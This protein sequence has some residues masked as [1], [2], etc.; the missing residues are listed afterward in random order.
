MTSE[1]NSRSIRLLRITRLLVP[2][3]AVSVIVMSVHLRA[4]QASLFGTVKHL[5]GAFQTMASMSRLCAGQLPGRD[6]DLYLG[7][8]PTASLFPAALLRGCRFGDSQYSAHLM[9]SLAF[10]GGLF[11]LVW[12]SHWAWAP[13]RSRSG[14]AWCGLAVVAVVLFLD[15]SMSPSQS[16]ILRIVRSNLTAPG[17]SLLMLR[18]VV[19]F[20]AAIATIVSRRLPDNARALVLGGL[21]GV[22]ILWS[23]DTGVPTAAGIGI[24]FLAGPR[25]GRIDAGAVARFSVGFLFAL[26]TAV[27]VT[28]GGRPS[29]QVAFRAGVADAQFWYFSASGDASRYFD[30]VDLLGWFRRDDPI[31]SLILLTYPFLLLRLAQ[32]HRR[33]SAAAGAAF[34]VGVGTFFGAALS[35]FGGHIFVRYYSAAML[36]WPF[37]LVIAL[38][39]SSR[40]RTTE[41]PVSMESRMSRGRLLRFT[42]QSREIAAHVGGARPA[43]AGAVSLVAITTYVMITQQQDPRDSANRTYVPNLAATIA[44]PDMADIELARSLTDAPGPLVSAYY[45]PAD[46]MLRSTSPTRVDSLIH[47]FGTEQ[48]RWIDLVEDQTAGTVLTT[49][50]TYSRYQPWLTSSN[51]P[52]FRALLTNY[53]PAG[54]GTTLQA[55]RRRDRPVA[56]APAVPCRVVTK[57]DSLGLITVAPTDP[58][59]IELYDVT[60]RYVLEVQP[61]W[62]PING[63]RGLLRLRQNGIPAIG[64]DPDAD[65]V[66]FPVVARG[67]STRQLEAYPSDRAKL[68]LQ[69][70][71][72]VPIGIPDASLLAHFNTTNGFAADPLT[73]DNWARGVSRTEPSFFFASQLNRPDLNVGDVLVFAGSG[74]RSISAIQ[75]TSESVIVTVDGALLDPE[76]DGHPHPLSI[77][78]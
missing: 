75:S 66:S 16:E 1:G 32:N 42:G 44:E 26:A 22:V 41:P 47:A 31:V 71:A 17:N 14:R 20:L 34:I 6:F 29:A 30:V 40:L 65:R 5:D 37:L 8:G 62:L 46:A 35:E 76:T 64:L 36:A 2:L 58:N 68:D 53:E 70:C 10:Y 11:T 55:W 43:L 51:W 50:P 23:L 24:A 28:S 77:Q 38:V 3:S 73:D 7:F 69:S 63:A 49:R 39:P 59:Q 9:T 19:P 15:V 60:V 56:A 52:F 72:A 12:V 74:A 21:A 13:G 4:V 67:E 61:S 18:Y 54:Q 33:G 57:E 27:L 48:E 78:P 25:D 45:N